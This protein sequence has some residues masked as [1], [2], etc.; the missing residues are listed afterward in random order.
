MQL[1]GVNIIIALRLGKD[2]FGIGNELAQ[3]SWHG[4]VNARR[5]LMLRQCPLQTLLQTLAVIGAERS[6]IHADQLKQIHRQR[7]G[8]QRVQYARMVNVQAHAIEHAHDA[9]KKAVIAGGN[10]QHRGDI[11]CYQRA[12][13]YDRCCCCRCALSRRQM[14][15]QPVQL[16]IVQPQKTVLRQSGD[17][18]QRLLC[19]H[20]LTNHFTVEQSTGFADHQ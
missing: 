1:K 3:T 4:I 15:C 19:R 8:I 17:E 14:L 10:Q 6:A 13:A 12:Q 20:T 5:H 2:D 7:R 18:I 9:G 16:V 11:F